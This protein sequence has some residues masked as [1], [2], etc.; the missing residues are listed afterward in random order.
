MKPLKLRAT[1]SPEYA[2]SALVSA[3][4]IL[5]VGLTAYFAGQPWLFPSLGPTAYLVA[6]YPQLP[7]ARVYNCLVGH[8]VGLGSGFAAVAMFN[9]WHAPIVPLHDVTWERLGAATV[10]I[11]LTVL[12]NHLLHSGHPPAAATTLLVA[13]GTFHTAWDAA[14]VIIG[15]V[16][17]VTVGEGLRFLAVRLPGGSG[18]KKDEAA[19]G[20]ARP[21]DSIGP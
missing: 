1:Y 3:A 8:L 17:L 12:L 21:T 15:V 13:L 18:K 9:A 20:S 4:S 7:S 11:G 16:L 6:A 14:L 10:A 2:A 19:S 5:V